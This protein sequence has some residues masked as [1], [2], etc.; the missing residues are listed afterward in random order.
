MENG[1]GVGDRTF[2][3]TEAKGWDGKEQGCDGKCESFHR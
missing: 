1:H 2:G 3:G